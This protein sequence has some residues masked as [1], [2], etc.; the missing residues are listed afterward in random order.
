MRTRL[1]ILAGLLMALASSPARAGKA[2]FVRTKPKSFVVPAQR[3]DLELALLEQDMSQPMLLGGPALKALRWRHRARQVWP[4]SELPLVPEYLLL[5]GERRFQRRLHRSHLACGARLLPLEDDQWELS[6]Y[7]RCFPGPR[8][9]FVASQPTSTARGASE[10][11]LRGPTTSPTRWAVKEKERLGELSTVDFATA[12]N[13]ADAL[14]RLQ[15]ERR[16]APARIAGMSVVGLGLS[17]AGAV[18]TGQAA[19]RIG[20]EGFPQTEN[21]AW[22]GVVMLAAGQL[23]LGAIPGTAVSGYQRQNRPAWFYDRDDAQRLVDEH[24]RQLQ[25]AEAPEEPPPEEEEDAP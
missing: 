14:R 17:I 20:D 8:P 4:D 3:L 25:P 7:G 13:D 9:K 12:V 15:R 19:W 2:P 23:V 16:A 5:K 21:Q 24:N 10:L 11:L 1:T 18:L 6:L 22:T